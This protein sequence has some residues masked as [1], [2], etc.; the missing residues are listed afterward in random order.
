MG[1]LHSK[2]A[3]KPCQHKWDFLETERLNDKNSKKLSMEER[4][5]GAKTLL[6]D[7]PLIELNWEARTGTDS[8]L[9]TG[10]EQGQS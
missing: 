4:N 9:G 6:T 8:K 7:N 10:R 2:T 3:Y 5:F 1:E